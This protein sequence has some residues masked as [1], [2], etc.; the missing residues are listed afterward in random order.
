MIRQEDKIGSI[1]VDKFADLIMVDQNI[2]EADID[3]IGDI[4]V[5]FTYP[6]GS[7][8]FLDVQVNFLIYIL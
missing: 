5:L 2:F 6:E 8:C 1:V 4:K 3:K 7:K